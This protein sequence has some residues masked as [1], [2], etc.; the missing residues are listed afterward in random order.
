MG[1]AGKKTIWITRAEP[2]AAATAERVRALGH[3]AIVAPL[4]QVRDLDEVRVDLDGVTAIAFT[5]ANGVRTF[6]TK[7]TLR[8]RRVFAVGAA[9]AAAA[10]AV[11]F[12]T[13]LSADGDVDALA[14]R[15]AQR[16]IELKGSVLHAGAAEPAGDL[17]G[18]LIRHGVEARLLALYETDVVEFPVEEAQRL[19]AAHIVLLHS[20]KAARALLKV[21]KAAPAPKLTVLALSKAVLKPLARANVGAKAHPP[22]PLEAALLNLID[23]SS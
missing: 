2:G 8:D 14:E 16:K 6:A 12:K 23:R 3:E 18:A 7:T 9:T 20:P 5:S 10:R 11:G 19:T 4:L 15:I 21:L 17:V 13:V 22:F 1:P